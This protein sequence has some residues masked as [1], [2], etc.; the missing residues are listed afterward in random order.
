MINRVVVETHA[1]SCY[2]RTSA[3]T[4]GRAARPPWWPPESG[5]ARRTPSS[6]RPRPSVSR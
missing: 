3:A 5:S 6:A 2:L 1:S 4:C